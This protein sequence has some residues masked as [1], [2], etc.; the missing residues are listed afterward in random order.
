MVIS[1]CTKNNWNKEKKNII[2][3]ASL[4]LLSTVP[5]VSA[6]CQSSGSVSCYDSGSQSYTFLTI[7]S[8][9]QDTNMHIC[10]LNLR[11]DSTLSCDSSFEGE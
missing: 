5:I 6:G 2:I 1:Y 3:P 8:Q 7:S 9:N 4:L 10:P 11:S